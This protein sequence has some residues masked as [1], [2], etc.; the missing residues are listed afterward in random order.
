MFCI[1]VLYTSLLIAVNA[2]K[3]NK[4]HNYHDNTQ[5]FLTKYENNYTL[6]SQLML[7]QWILLPY[8]STPDPF[9]QVSSLTN[10]WRALWTCKVTSSRKTRCK[11]DA[12]H[13]LLGRF[14]LIRINIHRAVRK[15]DWRNR[16]PPFDLVGEKQALVWSPLAIRY[17]DCIESVLTKKPQAQRT[18]TWKESMPGR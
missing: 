18:I 12:R 10:W 14:N 15:Q 11:S 5:H 9:R 1:C 6:H 2:I 16:K 4:S 7:L 8:A 3:H 17:C 13:S